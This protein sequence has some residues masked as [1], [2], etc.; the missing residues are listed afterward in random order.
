MYG[1]SVNNLQPIPTDPNQWDGYL[2]PVQVGNHEV[3][4]HK[5]GTAVASVGATIVASGLHLIA[6]AES[7]VAN[8][9]L[10]FDTTET[11]VVERKVETVHHD[12]LPLWSTSE[13]KGTRTVQVIDG[14][15]LHFR[16]LMPDVPSHDLTATPAAQKITNHDDLKKFILDIKGNQAEGWTVTKV[17]RIGESSDESSIA[18]GGGIGTAE[19]A[20]NGR[21]AEQYGEFGDKVFAEETAA[22]GV[23]IPSDIMEKTSREF[24]LDEIAQRNFLNKAIKAGFADYDELIAAYKANPNA[25]NE[26]ARGV[27]EDFLAFHRGPSFTVSMSRTSTYEVPVQEITEATRCLTETRTDITTQD[28]T[29]HHGGNVPIFPVPVPIVK[30][31]R[32]EDFFSASVTESKGGASSPEAAPTTTEATPEN[33]HQS[34]ALYLDTSGLE[35]PEWVVYVPRP[36]PP[37]EPK[38]ALTWY[39]TQMRADRIARRVLYGLGGLIGLGL[40]TVRLDAGY[41]PDPNS[42]K[43]QSAWEAIK[44]GNVL[45]D[46]LHANIGLPFSDTVRT[47]DAGILSAYC[48]PAQNGGRHTINV[49]LPPAEPTCDTS[50]KTYVNGELV[51]QKETNYP[52]AIKITRR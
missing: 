26:K 43:E 34:P 50:H 21:L 17:R 8:V 23:V 4:V 24:V 7:P 19:P 33:G 2:G 30:I 38:P 47:G 27:A 41:C 13:P 35:M 32:K 25:L 29:S 9:H 1:V 14:R 31:R 37:K 18:P 44:H 45:P 12:A 49:P 28:V 39:E 40:L 52:G 6:G 5:G 51:E 22:A 3:G 46:S 20:T 42:Y 11:R 16:A 48:P 15:E 36:K 10:G